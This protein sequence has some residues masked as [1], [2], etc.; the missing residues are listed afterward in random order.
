MNL[1]EE[2]KESTQ[3][4]EEDVLSDET[5]EFQDNNTIIN[6]NTWYIFHFFKRI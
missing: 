6:I 2:F 4:N 1:E 5:G 3:K